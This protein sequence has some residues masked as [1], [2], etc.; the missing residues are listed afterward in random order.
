MT[1]YWELIGSAATRIG[2][3]RVPEREVW[4]TAFF[5]DAYARL[6]QAAIEAVSGEEKYVKRVAFVRAG[7][8]YLRLIREM[9]P[10]I[11]RMSATKGKDPAAK[12]AAQAKW[13]TIWKEIRLIPQQHTFAI[14]GSYVTPGNRYLQ[15]Y[16][17]DQKLEMLLEDRPGFR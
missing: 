9:E 15:K 12:A 8:D 17:P 7:L 16:S 1:G 11:D 4:N 13:D 14:S 3:E 10:F 6:D 5:D 2:Y